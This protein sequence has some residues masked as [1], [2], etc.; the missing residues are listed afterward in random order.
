MR[1][2]A[3]FA[4]HLAFPAALLAQGW[5]I[6]RL[7]VRPPVCLDRCIAPPVALE[8]TSS[9]VRA[10][11]ADHVLRYEVEETFRNR[12]A[13][14]QEADYMYPLP[15]GAAFQ[16]LQLS[17]NGQLVSGEIMDAGRARSTYEEIV[18]RQ[19]DPAL[20]EWMGYGLLRARIFPINPG[21]E[22]RVVL[23]FQVIAPREGDA[24]RV[25]YQRGSGRTLVATSAD[26]HDA[27]ES[28][29]TL[30]YPNTGRCN[31]Y[32]P[33]QELQSRSSSG[34]QCV[35]DVSGEG[36]AVTILIPT[37]RTD[38]AAISVLANAPDSEDG[39]ALITLSPPAGR[40]ATVPR[41][42]TF[43]LDVS[44][45]MSGRKME[46]ARA[47]G[48]QLLRTLSRAD[49]FR[50]IDF[51]SDVRTFRDDFVDATPTNIAAATRY[52]SE[53][54]ANGGTNIDGA[55]ELALAP[56]RWRE[57][58]NREGDTD[59]YSHRPS[60][61]SEGRLSVVLFVTDGEPTIGERDPAAIAAHAARMRGSQRVFTFGLGADVNAQLIEQLALEGHGTAQFVRPEEDVERAVGLVASRL[62]SPIASD[63]RVTTLCGGNRESECVRLAHSL[64]EGPVDL[65]AGEDLVLLTRYAGSGRARLAF[66]GRSA[67]GPVHWETMVDFP[68]HERD[69]AFVPRLWATRRI[70]WLS[71]A[72][73]QNGASPEVDDELRTLGERY[74]IPTELTSY[75]VQE[76]QVA[77]NGPR[78]L[79]SS[80][81][82]DLAGRAPAAPA[83]KFEAARA[84]TA[85]RDVKSADALD[86]PI[87]LGQV[88]I[89]GEGTTSDVQK[90]GPT[91]LTDRVDAVKRAGDHLFAHNKDRW[92][93]V[94]FKSGTKIVKIK[95]F[96]PAYFAVLDAIPDL[97]AAFAVGD[98][99][100]V[101]GKHM[102]IEVGPDGA[103]ALSD[104][105]LRSLKEQW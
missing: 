83:A 55:L 86:K 105:E 62:T 43:V 66:D 102:A 75:L 96:S 76:Q 22:K 88:V 20:V 38:R 71:A 21:E 67:T 72:R 93:D 99:V 81:R 100:L 98:R 27:R 97:R 2:P 56:P 53:L 50:M 25:D 101:S 24:I 68:D 28:S 39:F 47:A 6:P 54:Q 41:D 12:G 29:F 52:L 15:A 103:D 64:P 70:G 59:E 16:E 87:T 94:S 84:A 3:L 13:T 1:A 73:R 95:P 36:A 7:P 61:R 78:Q 74:G 23:R 31:A 18:R 4:L 35:V 5:I 32:S 37:P 89:T 9:N 90:L 65:F 85:Q 91:V 63:L 69:N 34:S 80:I 8:R 14:V 58:D 57:D 79:D 60:D 49:R 26:T 77:T 82:N 10:T 33:T 44:G 104:A 30:R 17:I 45:S 48:K 42:I 40:S 51:S 19:R 11:L 92:V 46:Q